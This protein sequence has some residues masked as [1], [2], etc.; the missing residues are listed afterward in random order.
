MRNQFLLNPDIVFLNHGS[1]GAC[2]KD[3]FAEYQRWQMELEQNPVEFL[4]RKS[5][6]LL[7]AARGRL[8]EFL[9]ANPDNLVF[10]TNTT[11]GINAIAK[12]LSLTKG[13]E[14]LTTN[15]EYGACDNTWK[16]VCSKHDAKYIAADIPLPFESEKFGDRIWERVTPRTRVLYLS[17][18]TSTTAIIFPIKDICA[19]A[20]A[21][22]IITVIDGAH[23][24]GLIDVNLNELDAD[25]YVGNCHKWLMAP[26]GSAFLHARPSAQAL[27]EG[28]TTSWGYSPD[29]EGYTDFF[30]YAG[31]TPMERKHQ[32]QGTRD[33][34]AFLAV[35]AALNFRERHNWKS[36][37]R[38]C[39]SLAMETM[40]RILAVNKLNPIARPADFAQ[41]VAIPIPAAGANQLKRKLFENHRIEVP[42]TSHNNRWFVRPSVQVYNTPAELEK[43]ISCLQMFS[44]C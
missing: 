16:Q 43:L 35:P 13:D 15:H 36:K 11:M 31:K 26:K 19:K 20:R 29:V 10:I 1:F 42:I 21:A 8:A 34:S 17:H 27:I 30:G 5:A 18:V 44:D 32:W 28:L 38:E 14:V 24:P 25:F 9:G 12:S 41:M 39:H 33:I 22:G 3:V 4:G 7:A 37:Q 40:D 23:A 6:N 2:P